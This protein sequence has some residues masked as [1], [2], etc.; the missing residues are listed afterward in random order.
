MCKKK[1]VCPTAL[2]ASIEAKNIPGYSL[3]LVAIEVD[4]L[5]KISRAVNLKE[6]KLFILLAFEVF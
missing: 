6:K 2:G 1:L 5:R 4:I 3:A